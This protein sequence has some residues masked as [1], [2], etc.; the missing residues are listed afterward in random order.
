MLTT[1]QT[2]P[3]LVHGAQRAP[4]SS[5]FLRLQKL[6]GP[7]LREAEESEE[8]A[9]LGIPL[10]CKLDKFSCAGTEKALLGS[11]GFEYS[12]TCSSKHATV[13]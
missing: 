1:R 8:W 4:R 3:R 2:P 12:I 10:W 6:E 13:G 9:I 11:D 7:G 5:R